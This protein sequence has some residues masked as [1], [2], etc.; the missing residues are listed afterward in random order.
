M[1]LIVRWETAIPVKEAMMKMNY[2]DHLPVKGEKGYTLDA[3]QDELHH[4]RHGPTLGRRAWAR[5][6][7]C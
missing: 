4:F 5:T 2:G 3:P 6:R 7:R 1:N